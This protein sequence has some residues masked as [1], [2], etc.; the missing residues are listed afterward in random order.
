MKS[1]GWLQKEEPYSRVKADGTSE[2]GMTKSSYI[3]QR[4]GDHAEKGEPLS[5]YRGR[6]V[7]PEEP[8]RDHTL[9]TR[10]YNPDA[11]SRKRTQE[12]TAAKR[13]ATAKKATAKNTAAVKKAASKRKLPYK[14]DSYVKG[15]K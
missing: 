8:G 14:A 4:K 5:G 2:Q 7:D 9:W 3:R 13:R 11:K 10:K 1:G 6:Y 15:K 12:E